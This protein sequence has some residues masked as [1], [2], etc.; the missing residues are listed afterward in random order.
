MKDNTRKA[1]ARGMQATL[2][3]RHDALVMQ[4]A[5]VRARQAQLSAKAMGH[6]S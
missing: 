3:E 6:T 5:L 1:L 4:L 2:Q